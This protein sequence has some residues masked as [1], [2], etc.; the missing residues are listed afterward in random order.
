VVVVDMAA[1]EVVAVDTAAE[2]AVAADMEVV[3]VEDIKRAAAADMVAV[4]E[5]VAVAVDTIKIIDKA[6]FK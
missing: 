4:V 6:I 1:E 3:A 2:E 5:E